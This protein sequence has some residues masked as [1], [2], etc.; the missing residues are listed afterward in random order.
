MTKEKNTINNMEINEKDNSVIITINP[1]IYPLEIVYSATY[2]FIDRAYVL[3]DGDPEKKM[4][5]ELKLKE[6]G[7]LEELGREF[8]NELI[9]YA[10]YA[11]QSAR[12]QSVRDAL[13][14]KVFEANTVE[15]DESTEVTDSCDCKGYEEDSLGISTPWTPPKKTE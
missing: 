10:V 12:T 7:N 14:Q 5:V 1:K 9:N 8:N 15:K 6:K 4:L 2:I 3:I 13:V 11:V